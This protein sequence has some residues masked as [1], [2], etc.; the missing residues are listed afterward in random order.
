M[1]GVP[2]ELLQLEYELEPQVVP[3][4]ISD[5]LLDIYNQSVASALGMPQITADLITGFEFDM[6]VGQSLMLGGKGASGRGV[7]RARIVGAS[8]YALRLG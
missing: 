2:A 5:Q 8:P 4:V 1:T 7:E 3:V 6:V